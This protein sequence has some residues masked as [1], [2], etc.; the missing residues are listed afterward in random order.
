MK[1]VYLKVTQPYLSEN[2][3]QQCDFSFASIN[4]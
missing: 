1:I 4:N 3:A 2:L